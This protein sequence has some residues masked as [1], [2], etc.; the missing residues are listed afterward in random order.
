MHMPIYT[1]ALMLACVSIR[2]AYEKTYINH[3]KTYIC[4]NK[5]DRFHFKKMLSQELNVISG[6]KLRNNTK[7]KRSNVR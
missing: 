1:G 7:W 4:V 2:E 6:R 3:I 5:D